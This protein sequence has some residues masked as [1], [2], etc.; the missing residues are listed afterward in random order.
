MQTVRLITLGCKVNQYETQVIRENL[1]KAGFKESEKNLPADIYVINTCTV[2][3]KADQES[4]YYINRSQRLNP[5]AKIIVTGC[6]TEL[7]KRIISRQKG[8]DLIVKNKDKYRIAELLKGSG[9]NNESNITGF[10]KHTR[11]FL[12]IQDG[13]DNYCSYCKVPLVRGASRSRPLNEIVD[14][15]EVLV[16]NGFKEIVL[17]GI[18]LG[19]YG[20]DLGTCL[21]GRQEGRGIDLVSV[22]DELEKIKGLLRIRLSSIEAGDVTD[23]LINR[24]AKSEKICRHLHIPIQSGDDK[25]LKAM[26]RKYTCQDYLGLIRKIK[27]SIPKI[28]ITTDVL[29]GFP[30]EKEDNFQNT[31]DLVKKIKPLKVH[32][33]PYSERKAT[34]AYDLKDKIPSN[35]IR[36]RMICLETTA[37]KWAL[38]FQKQFLNK[39]MEVLIE[40]MIKDKS[41][42]WQ[43]YTDNYLKV[44]VYS[45]RDIHNCILPVKLKYIDR[46][47]FKALIIRG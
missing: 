45:D 29:V 44:S 9:R 6:L 35:I 43:G 28:A 12:K 4:L 30:G 27:K 5:K 39:K 8:I 13:C 10:Y 26:N 14:E 21:T 24:M 16:K 32:I 42:F 22:I 40:G 41:G 3:H 20:K 31:V 36:D 37:N 33:F 15:A 23:E 38:E 18:C 17:T 2:T 11:A 34:S 47:Y 1:L 46:D 7:D 19:S 25:I